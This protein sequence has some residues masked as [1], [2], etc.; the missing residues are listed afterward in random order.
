MTTGFIHPA[1]ALALVGTELKPSSN[2]DSPSWV[3]C[4]HELTSAATAKV[5]LYGKAC[6]MH[7]YLVVGSL[8]N[9]WLAHEKLLK[10]RVLPESPNLLHLRG[11]C[12][13]KAHEPSSLQHVPDLG[14]HYSYEHTT[15]RDD[16]EAVARWFGVYCNIVADYV[17]NVFDMGLKENLA[18]SAFYLASWNYFPRSYRK[19]F[20]D[21]HRDLLKVLVA[22][23]T[24]GRLDLDSNLCSKILD[25]ALEL[26]ECALAPRRQLWQVRLEGRTD[27]AWLPAETQVGDSVCVVP[28]TP[29]PFVI[30][31]FDDTSYTRIGDAYVFGT[32]LMEALGSER[33]QYEFRHGKPLG[34]NT[35]IQPSD[36]D[37]TNVSWITIC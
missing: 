36:E 31:E 27:A 26:P 19:H 33:Q 1:L 17:P 14:P 23:G 28:G 20:G 9:A 25:L 18:D 35:D 12:F 15:T 34:F 37:M 13:A 30:R 11:R 4:L 21:D 6:S 2:L 7:E 24:S 32:S 8:D 16:V 29:W 3:P 5:R 22:E 10:A